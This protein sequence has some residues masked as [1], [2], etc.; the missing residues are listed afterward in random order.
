MT[1]LLRVIDTFLL[2]IYLIEMV[3]CLRKSPLASQPFS[4]EVS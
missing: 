4:E 3:L 1:P 2:N